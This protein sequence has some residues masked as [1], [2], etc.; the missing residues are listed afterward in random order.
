[1][2]GEGSGFRGDTLLHAAVSGKADNLMAEDLVLIGIE[3][4][5]RHLRRNSHPNSIPHALS[6][7]AGGR[8]DTRSFAEFRVSGSFTVKL[9]KSFDFFHWQVEAREM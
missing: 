1:M 9:A 4:G 7:R 3:P 6:Q 8:L 2:A 5:L